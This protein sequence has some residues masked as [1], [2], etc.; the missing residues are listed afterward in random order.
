VSFKK[1]NWPISEFF[2]LFASPIGT[3]EML[4][5]SSEAQGHSSITESSINN[6]LIFPLNKNLSPSTQAYHMMTA[7]Y[8]QSLKQTKSEFYENSN[9]KGTYKNLRV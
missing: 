5:N 2:L 1:A 8:S 3:I 9:N 7:Y 6:K 4:R